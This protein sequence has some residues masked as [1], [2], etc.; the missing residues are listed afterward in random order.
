MSKLNPY[1]PVN[2]QFSELELFGANFLDTLRYRFG[3]VYNNN[4]NAK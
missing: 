3:R 2:R 1:K 4:N